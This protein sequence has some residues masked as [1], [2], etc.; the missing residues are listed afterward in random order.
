MNMNININVQVKQERAGPQGTNLLYN[1][2]FKFGLGSTVP[3]MSSS[4]I[5]VLV[6]SDDS[7]KETKIHT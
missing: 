4:S 5:V 7:W 2:Q 6:L 1:V 3:L